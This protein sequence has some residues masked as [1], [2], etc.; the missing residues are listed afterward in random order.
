MDTTQIKK[1]HGFWREHRESIVTIVV[2][3][4]IMISLKYLFQLALHSH[5][6]V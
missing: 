5:I 4:L 2:I 1:R 3:L 6:V